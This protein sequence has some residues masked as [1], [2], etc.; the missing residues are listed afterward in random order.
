MAAKPNLTRDHVQGIEVANLTVTWRGRPLVQ[1]IS[2]SAPAGKVTALLGANGAGKSTTLRAALGLVRASGHA[3]FDGARL[4]T[5]PWPTRT[6]GAVLDTRTMSPGRTGRDHLRVLSSAAGL[7]ADLDLLLERVG[8]TSA[9]RRS[10]SG[11]SFG[12]RQRLAIAG[13]LVTDPRILIL[14][15]PQD[16]LDPEGLRWLRG[17]LTDLAKDGRTILMSTHHLEDVQAIADRVVVIR[18]GRLVADQ[19]TNEL[20]GPSGSIIQV[21]DPERLCCLLDDAA[22]NAW[23]DGPGSV[24]CE[25]AD[26]AFAVAVAVRAGIDVH[27]ARSARGSIEDAFLELTG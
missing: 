12:M 25:D 9:G 24:H 22:H 3:T 2:F 23:I 10:T 4:G 15:E 18:R 26:A 19:A 6:V 7:H 13:A 5:L 17:L 27:G 11:Y 20:G 8:L 16:G 14:D 1:D 21:S